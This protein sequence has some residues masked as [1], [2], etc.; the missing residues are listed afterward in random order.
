MI[1]RALLESVVF[2]AV[3]G[4]KGKLVLVVER[5]YLVFLECLVTKEKRD[6]LVVMVEW[7]S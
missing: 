7:V 2:L 1:Y 5:V 6:R 3:K 4:S